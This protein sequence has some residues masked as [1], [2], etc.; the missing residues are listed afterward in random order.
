MLRS[1]MTE[2]SR[3]I[4]RQRG[5]RNISH[6]KTALEQLVQQVTVR[7]ALGS[8][9]RE[10]CFRRPGPL[11]LGIDSVPPGVTGDEHAVIGQ[12]VK[13]RLDFP[14][15]ATE[16]YSRRG[17]CS[18]ATTGPWL[19]RDVRAALGPSLKSRPESSKLLSYSC[20]RAVT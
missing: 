15:A 5:Q 4:E 9:I 16:W 10:T 1:R 20:M 14:F 12:R 2:I 18:M 13:L 17:P 11:L 8:G 6:P 7:R 3:R 19:H